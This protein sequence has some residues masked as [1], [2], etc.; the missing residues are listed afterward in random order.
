MRIGNRAVKHT[1]VL[2][3]VTM[4]AL[5]GCG[6]SKSSTQSKNIQPDGSYGTLPQAAG[7]PTEGGTVTFA[8]QP[9]SDP[10]WIFP[11]TP[12]ANSS[13]NVAYQFQYLMWRPLYWSPKGSVPTINDDLSLAAQPTAASDG[14]TFTIKLKGTYKWSDGTPVSANDIMFM[15]DLYRAAVKENPSNSGNYTPGQFPDNVTSMTSPDAN[16]VVFT[17]DKVYNPTW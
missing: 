3:A 4:L 16:T 2:A 10:N 13:V 8:Q 14:K 9:G 11:I 7:S 17:F 1:V 6:S 15:V 12:A 5:A